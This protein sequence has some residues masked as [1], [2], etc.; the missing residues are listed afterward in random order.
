MPVAFG[1]GEHHPSFC[2]ERIIKRLFEVAHHRPAAIHRRQKLFPMGQRLA[3]K[4]LTEECLQRLLRVPRRD[5]RIGQ[6]VHPPQS[7]QQILRKLNFRSANHH[8]SVIG[9]PVDRIHR[10]PAKAA[11]LAR[12]RRFIFA[13]G[14]PE[15]VRRPGNR[16][17]IHRHVDIVPLAG[18]LPPVQRHQD[19]R[20]GHQRRRRISKRNPRRCG[21]IVSKPPAQIHEPRHRLHHQVMR[22]L[23]RMASL[24]PE[25]RNR[26][27]DNLGVARRHC[28]ISHAQPLHHAGAERF[29]KHIRLLGE[30]QQQ[31]D[32]GGVLEVQLQA[33][34]AARHIAKPHAPAIGRPLA[35]LPH[36]LAHAI[37]RLHHDDVRAM[38]GHHHGHVWPGKE[39]R[40]IEN[41]ETVEFHASSF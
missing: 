33:P 6:Q 23:L 8:K 28:L 39:R 5:F 19:A 2:R 38:V 31:L 29:D 7:G 24:L 10:R 12:P 34:L 14:R 21:F 25:S 35:N 36:R 30:L 18:L 32:A 11:H 1:I 41:F 15:D 3:R 4:Y 13:K 40:E 27:V 22:G 9:C 17:V 26:A 16:G 37:G 20:Q